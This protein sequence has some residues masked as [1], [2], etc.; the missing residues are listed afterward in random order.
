MADTRV[1][2]Y[3][4]GQG[5]MEVCSYDERSNMDSCYTQLCL[6]C[7]GAGQIETKVEVVDEVS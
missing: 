3:C 6:L 1:C 7:R 4:M 2:T 5:E